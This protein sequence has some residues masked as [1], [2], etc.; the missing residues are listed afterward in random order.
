MYCS[1]RCQF[2]SVCLAPAY[3]FD[4]LVAFICTLC[5][6]MKRYQSCMMSWGCQCPQLA[7]DARL[8]ALPFH[9]VLGRARR[10]GSNTDACV[11][12]R[13]DEYLDFLVR[14]QTLS[15]NFPA[16]FSRMLMLTDADVIQFVLDA[17]V[18]GSARCQLRSTF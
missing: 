16:Q 9:K 5:P 18:I 8:H 3:W 13:F 6:F 11:I 12:S 10:R 2:I 1:T 4:P 14:S 15:S 17:R 7:C